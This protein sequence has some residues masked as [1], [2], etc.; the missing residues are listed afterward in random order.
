[1]AYK[2]EPMDE[3]QLIAILKEEESAAASYHDSEI[4][5]SQAEAMDRY[6]AQPYG[7]EVPNRSRVVTHDIEDLANWIIPHLKRVFTPS[8]DLISVDDDQTPDHDEVLT[9]TAQYLAHIFYKKS[10]GINLIH[11]FAF[12]G[13]VQKLGILRSAWEEPEPH[14]PEILEGLDANQLLR[15]ANDP[16]YRILEVAE[17]EGEGF[18]LEVE[19]PDSELMAAPPQGEI[20][21]LLDGAAGPQGMLA[22]MASRPMM[23]QGEAPALNVLYDVKI[24]R[25]PRSGTPVFEVIP[26]ERFRISARAP[27]IEAAPYH[28][29]RF[30]AYTVELCRD[31]PDKAH[32]LDPTG[33]Y[34]RAETDLDVELD[35]R[36]QA[37]FPDQ[38]SAS[39]ADNKLN[40]QTVWVELEYLRIDYD[41]DSIVELRRIQRV[42]DVIL[43]N[44]IVR[45][46]EFTI[47]SPIRIPHRAIGRSLADTLMDIQK[48]RT[49]ITRRAMD[50]L[51]QSLMPRTYISNQ[52]LA[53]DATLLDRIL[54]HDVGDVIPVNG[55]PNE[56]VMQEVSA[57]VTA[58]AFLALEYWDR[59]SEEASGVNRHAMGIQPQA[60]TD[61]KGGIEN[62]QAAANSRIGEVASSLAEA[63][64]QALG[65]MLRQIVKHEHTEQI[66][67]V[68]SKM[69]RWDPRRVRDT[70]D[71]SVHVGRVDTKERQLLYLSNIAEK[72]EQI[73]SQ[74][75]LDNPLVGL[76]EY[77]NTLVQMIEIMGYRDA[78]MFVKEPD[79][80]WQPE[81]QQD[82]KTKEIEG[83]LQLQSQDQQAKQGLAQAEAQFS[84]Q[85]Q[86]AEF[87]HKQQLE[88][89]A[90]Q[91]QD[92]RANN[93]AQRAHELATMKLESDRQ[94][95][96]VK[97]E[98][99]RELAIIRVQSEQ[100][101]S[102]IRLAQERE[103]AEMRMAQERELAIQQMAQE[104]ELAKDAHRAKVANGSDGD[105]FRSGGA[106]NA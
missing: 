88:Q 43:T 75:G 79:P 44:D 71:V 74:I 104:K 97:A 38:P 40:R 37:R 53:Q 105:E 46:S 91:L 13:I 61:T 80:N 48:I 58:P 96:L 10:N 64:G 9:S 33:S 100:Q 3:E 50:S 39:W 35:E 31:Y 55:N 11:D 89:M 32:E 45:E 41:S 6:F 7:D 34:A 16:D 76:K 8:D 77:R 69:V 18:A 60:I 66:F 90:V 106:L 82:P 47:W 95:A 25:T 42:N 99:E 4:A 52:A 86:Q 30:E 2:P 51:S 27:S 1:M 73:V 67:K 70:M 19:Q 20:P 98:S 23:G 101:I 56:V 21:G 28:A 29:C 103:L 68:S 49:V 5:K 72:Q 94:I 59:R 26:P 93:D 78:K 84:L 63:I 57:D 12:N 22:P 24:Q 15:Y 87:Q 92:A 54:D 62:L 14:P 81:P 83:K 65:K 17:L 85:K 36:T 102:A